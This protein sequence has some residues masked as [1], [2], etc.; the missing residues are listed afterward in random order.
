MTVIN[1]NIKSVIAANSLKING[2]EMA[3]AMEQLST[4]KRINSAS[5][6]AAGLAITQSMTAQSRGLNTAVRNA[7]DAISMAQTAEGALIEVSNMLQRMRELAVQASTGTISTTQRTYLANEANALADQIDSTINNTRWNGWQ[8]LS[9]TSMTTGFEIQ[10]SDQGGEGSTVTSATAAATAVGSRTIT[11]TTTAAHGLVVG[12]TVRL[13]QASAANNINLQGLY[14]VESQANATTIT[15]TAITA[16]SSTASLGG[17][18]I[19]KVNGKMAVRGGDLSS[20]TKATLL[21][22]SSNMSDAATSSAALARIDTGLEAVNTARAN[23]G[24]SVNRLTSV[25]DN[26]TNVSQNLIESRS[27]ILDTDY[28]A[29]TTELARTQIIQQAGMAVLAQANQQP[30]SVL[31]LLRS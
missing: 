25:V 5:D 14:R 10:T 6:D 4:G 15:V 12:D 27:R 21:Q 23:L 19:T 11:L 3:N 24:A 30:Q 13:A 7:N 9:S 29:A 20:V 22:A 28:A 1:T 8:V 16:A 2:R 17:V 26:L 31:S 18:D